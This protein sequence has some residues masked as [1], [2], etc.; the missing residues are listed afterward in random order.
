M[1]VFEG[2]YPPSEDSF[3]LLK[4]VDVEEGMDVLEV[5]TGSGVIAIHCAKNGAKV[6]A[7]DISSM[8][9]DCAESNAARNAVQITF[10]QGD[11]FEPVRGRK[12][13]FDVIVFNAPYLPAEAGTPTDTARQ[14]ESGENGI[15]LTLRFLEHCTELLKKGGKVFFSASSTADIQRLENEAGRYMQLARV[16]SEHYFFEELFVFMGQTI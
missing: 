16:A 14:T 4:A 11:L 15:D 7:T 9:L 3:L 10:L 12:G 13:Q 5:G 1:D 6:V 8:A 2:V